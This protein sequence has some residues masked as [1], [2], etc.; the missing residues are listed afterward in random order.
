[1]TDAKLGLGWCHHKM[2]GLDLCCENSKILNSKISKVVA[3]AWLLFAKDA[4][5]I[6]NGE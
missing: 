2:S 3:D 4:D 5:D 1:M 6:A